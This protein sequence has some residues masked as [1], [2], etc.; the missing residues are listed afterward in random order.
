MDVCKN[1]SVESV[2][3][4]DIGASKI[5]C[6]IVGSNGSVLAMRR[7]PTSADRDADGVFDVLREVV[8]EVRQ[9][10]VSGGLPV[11]VACGVGSVGPMANGGARVSP[12]NIPSWRDFPLLSRI[13]ELAGLPTAIDN[14]AKA[15]AL[16]EGWV[17]G[18]RGVK[19]YISMVVSTGVGGGIVLDGKLLDGHGGNA[20]H[21]GHVIV[22][23]DG[24]LCACGARGCL[25]AEASGSAI[26]AI[27]GRHPREASRAMIERTGTLVGLAVASVANLLDLK[28]CTIA[29]SVALGYGK[30]FFDAANRELAARSRISYAAGARIEP[31]GL[32]ADGPLVGAGAV[33]WQRIG[34][35]D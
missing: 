24:R 10:G 32:G 28:L 1:G 5:S 26:Q 19:D 18:A 29:G 33:G 2:L 31:C 4:I 15:L 22:S 27:T 3:A 20:G 14:D 21:I 16:G 34:R 9:D 11:P 12:L 7:A 8:V 17:G 35:L 23:P 25:E 13:E 6:G 30:Q